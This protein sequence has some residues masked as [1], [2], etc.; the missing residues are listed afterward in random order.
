MVRVFDRCMDKGD[1]RHRIV[2]LGL[3]ASARMEEI[4]KETRGSYRMPE[5]LSAE[6]REACLTYTQALTH[7]IRAYVPG[8]AY[9]NWTKKSHVILHYADCSEF[10][11][12]SMGSCYQGEELMAIVRRLIQ[13]VARASK[14]LTA[15][16]RALER[17]LYGM[18]YKMLPDAQP[19]RRK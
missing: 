3:R 13:A 8:H 11:H 4:L 10:I 18:G 5:H 12:P 15:S 16:N 1:S 14:P 9:F 17:W 19:W 6:F 7:S 2:M